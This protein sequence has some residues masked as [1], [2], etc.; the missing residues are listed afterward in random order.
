MKAKATVRLPF[1]SPKQLAPIVDGLTPE[2]QRQV[3]TR[4]KVTLATEEE[5]LVLVVEAEDTVA[6]RVALN[7]YLRWI[8]SMVNVLGVVE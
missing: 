2:I 3:G 1:P 5:V 6:L 7:A 8:N 4:S